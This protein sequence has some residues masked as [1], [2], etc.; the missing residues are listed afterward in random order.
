M[1]RVVTEAGPKPGVSIDRIAYTPLAAAIATGRSRSRLYKALK[2]GELMA[3]KD[4]RATLIEADELKRWIG[5]LPM[6]G[7]QA[8]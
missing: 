8:A 3:R 1:S 7:E 4:G 6:M 2:A 5:S